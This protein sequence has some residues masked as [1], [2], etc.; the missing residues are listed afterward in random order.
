MNFFRKNNITKNYRNFIT[1]KM[2]KKI[3]FKFLFLLQKNCSK[4]LGFLTFCALDI[5]YERMLT[6]YA[7][8]NLKYYEG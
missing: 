7:F 3:I 5:S 1:H 4:K 2:L 8:Y 6:L